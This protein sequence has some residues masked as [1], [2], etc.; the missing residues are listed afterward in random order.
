MYY[1]EKKLKPEVEKQI[2]RG[3]FEISKKFNH[4]VFTAQGGKFTQPDENNME[5]QVYVSHVC[6]HNFHPIFSK[7]GIETVKT[8]LQFGSIVY[9]KK[10]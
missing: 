1:M 10:G 2:K 4:P 7:M 9:L 3:F 5:V 6:L 8:V